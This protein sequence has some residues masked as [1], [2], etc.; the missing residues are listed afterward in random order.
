MLEE[1]SGRAPSLALFDSDGIRCGPTGRCGSCTATPTERPGSKFVEAKGGV[2]LALRDDTQA[3]SSTS[4][5][6]RGST[7][8]LESRLATGIAAPCSSRI[9]SDAIGCGGSSAAGHMAPRWSRNDQFANLAVRGDL[10]GE[11]PK[12]E[13]MLPALSEKR[14]F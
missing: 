8:L 3:P 14:F 9:V 5:G 10:S 1:A 13:N 7:C 12:V 2:V 11:S 4:L 6:A